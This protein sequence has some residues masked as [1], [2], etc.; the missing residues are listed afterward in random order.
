M[1][2]GQNNIERLFVQLINAGK[3][4]KWGSRWKEVSEHRVLNLCKW[5]EKF[6]NEVTVDPEA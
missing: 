2:N 6:H 5:L 3:K 1:A 4:M